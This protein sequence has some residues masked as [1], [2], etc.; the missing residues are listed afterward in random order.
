MQKPSTLLGWFNSVGIL[1]HCLL[2]SL[3]TVCLWCHGAK[4]DIISDRTV[5]TTVTQNGDRFTITD[6]TR[7]GNNL[8]HSFSQFSIKSQG[9]AVFNNATDIQNIFSRVTGGNISDIDGLIQANGSANLFLLNPAGI[10]FRSHAKLDIG[11]SFVGS[12]AN[13][14]KF[15]DGA[16]F[17]I[18]PTSGA[19]ILTLAVP[20][21]LQFGT[22]PKP[23]QVEGT[24]HNLK[25]VN[26][27]N[28]TYSPI[29]PQS[30]LT[31]TQLGVKPG[32]TLALIGGDISLVGGNL[33][34]TSGRIEL[35]SV[36]AGT[37]SFEGG[38]FNY[39]NVQSFRDI[40]LSQQA[41]ADASG[42]GGGAIQMQGAQVSLT[43]GSVALIQNL[44]SQSSGGINI[45][46]A[47]LFEAMGTDAN[48]LIISGLRNETL[49]AGNN[50]DITVTTRQLVLEQGGGII[51]S[52]YDSGKS[53][54]ITINVSDS[55]KLIGFAPVNLIA[56]SISTATY[57]VG[58]AGDINI[59]TRQLTVVNSG[60]ISAGSLGIGAAGNVAVKATELIELDGFIPGLFVP[61]SISS[62]SFATGNAG[63]VQID[64][65][66]LIISNGGR[67]D[68]STF[69]SGNGGNL[70]INATDS[71]EVRGNVPGSRN[72][73]LISSS[74]SILDE[75]L[76]QQ[77]KLPDAP[78]GD[79]GSLTINTDK[80]TVS[81]GA[82]INVQ[83]EGSGN[84]GVLRINADSIFLNN[85]GRITASA[86]SGEGGDLNLQVQNTI[87]MRQGSQISSEAG[88]TGNGGNLNINAPFIIGLE[89]SDI[90]A[91]AFQGNGGKIQLT[92]KGIFGLEYRPQ[93]T[94][95][96]DITA[97]SQFGVSGEVQINNIGL[98]PNS[99]LV[100]LPANVTDPS[101]QIS[102][103]CADSQG[104]S[105]VATGRGGI[106]QNPYLSVGSDRHWSDT[107]D[108]STFR[109]TGNLTTQTTT[110]PQLPIQ[111]TSWHRNAQGKIELVAT[112]SSRNV[113]T[114]TC[115]AVPKS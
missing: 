69:A 51:T 54:N 67:V 55:L 70:V 68:S 97:S 101:Q 48:G 47:E 80:L 96:N 36:G 49:A 50:G 19:P 88:G 18:S 28:P 38:T 9:S 82:L 5:N 23:I 63:N 14:I 99:G 65:T 33:K 61:S 75:S 13:S 87:I 93:L 59:S 110:S 113:Q 112:S 1:R 92:T 26:S 106:P 103:G 76:R 7:V 43:D 25:L 109:R 62:I 83:N 16:E 71:I 22:T 30:N 46:A 6:G 84:A 81:D 107:R 42:F 41:L 17:G 40:R 57:N 66:R 64:T 58:S 94:P 32:K 108:I 104:S 105:F 44:G 89:N 115:A 39:D 85:R 4:A 102:T 114:L 8:F 98:D 90:I 37:V 77:F 12:T 95:E 11:G 53:G 74:A 29:D 2:L 27:A 31:A 86:Q 72:P 111:A 100:E 24:G 45:K 15:A 20:M 52:T 35:G 79:S 34:A 60:I 21:G 10:L 91:N 56:S 78:T 3:G 73:S